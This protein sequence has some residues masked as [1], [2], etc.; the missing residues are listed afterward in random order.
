[1]KNHK[2]ITII[3][4]VILALLQVLII[5]IL[6]IIAIWIII[7]IKEQKTLQE[8]YKV[9]IKE[10]QDM[11][12]EGGLTNPE[13]IP[14]IRQKE[15]IDIV[16]LNPNILSKITGALTALDGRINKLQYK[17]YERGT[18]LH[19]YLKPIE[20]IYDDFMNI[21]A[22]D[23]KADTLYINLIGYMY[24]NL[25]TEYINDI[26][27]DNPNPINKVKKEFNDMVMKAV[28]YINDP[29]KRTEN[30]KQFREIKAGNIENMAQTYRQ[31][32]VLLNS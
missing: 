25:I 18:D 10:L 32:Y 28:Q 2:I 1:M 7:R 31:L 12:T 9:D 20:D 13:D 19:D 16:S 17:K 23:I 3:L 27:N 15:N 6:A 22:H 11:P 8:S 14:S 4:V 30:Q 5:A 29:N 21:L 26:H 24:N